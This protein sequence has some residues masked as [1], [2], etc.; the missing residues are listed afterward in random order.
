MSFVPTPELLVAEDGAVAVITLNNP[1]MGNAFTDSMH[2]G[3][4]EIWDELAA[5]DN[6]RAVLITGAGKAFSTGGNIAGFI[7]N[8]KDPA[9]ALKSVEGARRILEAQ[10]RFPKPL[11][12]AVNGPAVGLG[13]SVALGADIILIGERAYM[14]DTHVNVGL[15]AGDGGA[16]LWP[17]LMSMLKAKEYLFTGERIPAA[18]AVTLGLA[19]RVVPDAD[20]RDEALKLAHKLAEQPAQALQDTKRAL[21]LHIQAAIARVAPFALAKEALSFGSEDVG[22]AIASFSK[23]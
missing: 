7:R 20:L 19:N 13:C 9:R 15:V 3:L 18:E 2:A 5:D 21:N 16:E 12:A 17:L 14:A 11:V 6:V 23:S 22:K 4:Q 1:E 8:Y 10:A